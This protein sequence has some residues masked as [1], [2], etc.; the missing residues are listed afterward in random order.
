MRA[1]R[2]H[3]YGGPEVMVLEDVPSPG[4]L[5][6][7]EVVVRVDYAGVNPIDWKLRR[8]NLQAIMS[9]PLPLTLGFDFAGTVV[10][11]GPAVTKLTPGTWPVPTMPRTCVGCGV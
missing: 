7:S 11:A 6:D 10:A 1:V 4:V 3:A 9:P 5:G 2:L 8:G